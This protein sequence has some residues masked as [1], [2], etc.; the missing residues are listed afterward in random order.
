MKY[1]PHSMRSVSHFSWSSRALRLHSLKLAAVALLVSLVLPVSPISPFSAPIAS[2]AGLGAG[3]EYHPLTPLRIYDSRVISPVHEANPGPK[4]ATPDQPTFDIDLLDKLG[5]GGVPNRPAD[6]LS[7]VVNITVASPTASGWLNAYGTGA[8]AGTASIVNFTANQVVPN[9]TIVRPGTDGKLTI[10]L[11]TDKT[12]GQA[13]VIVDVFGWFSTSSNQQAGARLIPVAPGRLLDTRDANVPLGPAGSTELAIPGA[14]LQ[15]GVTIPNDPNIVGVVLNLTGVNDTAT[16]TGTFLSVVPDLAPGQVPTTSNVN[17]TRGQ[18]KPNMVIVPL[19]ADG[20]VHIYN[21]SGSANVV[22]D[23]AGYLIANQSPSTRKGRVIPLTSPFRVFDTR[24]PQW[25]SVAL[26]AGQAEDWSFSDFISSVNI[27]G[28]SVGNQMAVIGNLT[29]AC[30]NGTASAPCPSLGASGPASFLTVY[31]S[32]AA[33][34]VASN[35]NTLTGAGAVP[36]LAIL[37]YSA[38]K[39]VRV[40]NQQ[41]YTHYLYDAAAVIL[42]D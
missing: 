41:G 3:G 32:D 28:V 4:P 10:K 13:E 9:L 25:G 39:T 27:G 42:D 12:N 2:A 33:R 31:P 40:F 8:Q 17:L 36:N 29:A 22:V 21:N 14:V 23:V 15:N 5:E 35:L 30:T 37:K 11:F 7:V 18:V 38:T 34:P 6:V 16:S 19:G 26:G 20:K 24:D 1:T